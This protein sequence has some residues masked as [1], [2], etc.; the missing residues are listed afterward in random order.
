MRNAILR[1]HLKHSNCKLESLY[2]TR[3]NLTDNAAKDLG[4]ALKHSNCK[5]E[6]FYLSDNKFTEEGRQY[7]TDAAKQ[8]NCKVFVRDF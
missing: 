4:E 2:L 6:S 5:L 8:S 3:N 1:N 7:L